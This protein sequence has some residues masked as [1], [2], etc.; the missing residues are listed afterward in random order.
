[1]EITFPISPM[2][3]PRMT[4]RDKWKKRTVIQRWY[5]FK[6]SINAIAASEGYAVADRLDIVFYIPMPK[7]W[8]K[9]KKTEMY[10]KPHQQRPDIDNM[11]KGFMDALCQEDSYVWAVNA[12]KFWSYS[13]KIIVF[14]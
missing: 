11:I 12:E 14:E 4:Q 9:K 6:D 10:A 7:S 13:G 8:S 5:E 1:M 3:K 2:G